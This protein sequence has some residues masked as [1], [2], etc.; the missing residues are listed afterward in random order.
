[1]NTIDRAAKL[2]AVNVAAAILKSGK[3]KN[4]KAP[5]AVTVDGT[6]FFQMQSLRERVEHYLDGFL[7]EARFDDFS[8]RF[9]EEMC[10][11]S[12]QVS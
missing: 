8:R 9:P 11:T 5:V 10:Q 4:V 6:T 2:S 12:S 7:V 3:G 1:M